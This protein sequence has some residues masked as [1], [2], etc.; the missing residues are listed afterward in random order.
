M[1]AES[2]LEAGARVLVTG[3]GGFVGGHVARTLAHEGYHVRA[4]CRRPVEPDPGDP[5]IEWLLGDL[6][7]GRIREEAIRGVRG[8]VH[9]AGRVTLGL[10]RDGMSRR[11]NVDAT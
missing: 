2:Y 3:A 6:T 11:V 1:I 10:D 7:D 4:L 5:E 9:V 8:V